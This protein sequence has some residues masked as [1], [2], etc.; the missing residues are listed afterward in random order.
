MTGCTFIGNSANTVGG[1]ISVLYGANPTLTNC[2]MW[3]NNAPSAPEISNPLVEVT[4]AYSNV[5]AG[6]PGIGNLDASPMFW[7][8]PNAGPD[9][10]WGTGDDDYGDLRLLS[11]SPCIDAG[12]N[13]LVPTDVTTDLQ[14]NSRFFD[15][16]ATIDTGAGTAPIV[17][18]G[19]YEFGSVACGPTDLDCD[20]D[21]DL[22]DYALF[23]YCMTGANACTP[24][25]FYRSDNDGDNEVNLSDFA[26]CQNEFAP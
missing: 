14:G 26:E 4:V 8:D 25:A 17:D 21:V 1:G 15:D 7:R 18:I 11:S 24:L 5:Q 22:A 10:V 2:I 19:A 3:G 20:G 23:W 6:W 16:P 13:A 12:N 9:G